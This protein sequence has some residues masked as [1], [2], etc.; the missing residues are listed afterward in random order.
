[1]LL[2]VVKKPEASLYP[3]FCGPK[4][5]SSF[6]I[7]LS[8]NASDSVVKYAAIEVININGLTNT[9]NNA[10]S[11]HMFV[12]IDGIGKFVI[13]VGRSVQCFI[14]WFKPLAPNSIEQYG[15]SFVCCVRLDLCIC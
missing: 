14:C 7:N 8:T 10:I 13:H 9:I 5:P 6:E 15:H 11:N 2:I 1:M 12:G 3:F 4:V